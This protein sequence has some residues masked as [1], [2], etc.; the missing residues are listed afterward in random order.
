MELEW[1]LVLPLLGVL[2]LTLLV[3][4]PGLWSDAWGWGWVRRTEKHRGDRK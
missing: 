3:T 4:G 1:R 2:V